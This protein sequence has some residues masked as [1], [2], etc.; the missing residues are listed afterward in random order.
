MVDGM[1]DQCIRLGHIEPQIN[2]YVK[3]IR[4]KVI[5]SEGK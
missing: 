2:A 1:V 4:R 3:S 5:E